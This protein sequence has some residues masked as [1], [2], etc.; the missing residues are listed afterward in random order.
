MASDQIAYRPLGG[1][2]RAFFSL[3]TAWSERLYLGPDHLLY[4]RNEQFS[5]SYKRF[6]FRDIRALV[7]TES[8]RRKTLNLVWVLLGLG[9]SLL[10]WMIGMATDVYVGAWLQ[11]GFIVMF[12]LC[13]GV[14]VALGPTCMCYVNTAVHTHEL[15]SLKRVRTATKV[16]DVVTPLITAAQGVVTPEELQAH[17]SGQLGAGAAPP[18]IGATGSAVGT[19]G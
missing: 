2:A 16:F 10:G 18:V 13:V 15:V 9:C 7:M 4:L 3:A 19:E 6:Y 11:A 14:N 5:E 1:K 8:S 17:S 12:S